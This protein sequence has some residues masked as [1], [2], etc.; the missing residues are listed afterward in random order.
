MTTED[1]PGGSTP[2]GTAHP[3]GVVPQ[4]PPVRDDELAGLRQP[5][6]PIALRGYDRD[7]V[8]AYIAHVSGVISAL[9]ANSSP[10]A[11]V[12]FAL[13]QVSEETKGILQRAHDA[14]DEL[15]ARSRAQ[16]QERID[17]A[18]RQARDIVRDAETRARVLDQDADEIWQERKRLIDDVQRVSDELSEL[19]ESASRRFPP[20][21]P[22]SS[23]DTVPIEGPGQ[24]A[25]PPPPEGD[26]TA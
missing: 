22:D 14:A 18:E 8:D 11:A 26:A 19:A 9:E 6:F 2:P 15:T 17:D 13:D 7:A 16:A 1:L 10:Q 23:A 20:E 12:R 24:A 5:E 4:P 25:L 21:T 3:T